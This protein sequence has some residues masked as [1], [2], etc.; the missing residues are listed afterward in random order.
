ME[1]PENGPAL[2][3]I[4]HVDMDSFYTSVDTC[5]HLDLAG[6]PIVIGAHPKQ[7]LGR[8]VV[9]ICSYEARKN[10]IRSTMPVAQAFHL[11]PDTIF[12]PPNFPLSIQISGAVMAAL[13]S[14]GFPFQQVS[15]DEA[16]LD[17]S[18]PGRSGSSACA[19]QLL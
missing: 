11:C 12:L 18:S 9:S 8:G 10:G 17:V 16:F 19:S 5:E 7:G 13:G 3:I 15:I 1:I 6:K 14:Y 4:V 2:R